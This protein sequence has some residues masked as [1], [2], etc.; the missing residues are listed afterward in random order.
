MN[1]ELT[2]LGKRYNREWIFRNLS[3]QFHIDKHYAITGPNGSGKSTLLQIIA[4][5]TIYN[6]GKITYHQ[7]NKTFEPEKIYR[8]ISFAAP[9]LDLVEEMTL[10]E[11]LN[12]HH[13]MKGWIS[14]LDTKQIILLLAL[15]KSAHKQLRYFSSGMKQRVKLAQAIFSNVPA[16]LLDEPATNLD[17]E[18]IQLYKNLVKDYCK[19][20]LVIISSNDKEEYSFCEEIIDMMDYK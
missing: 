12:F 18:G 6:E 14:L 15:E 11:F 17:E 4:G 16:V 7:L 3:F 19:D 8:K 5:S 2:N 9:Y 10:N 13:K 1:I 20:R